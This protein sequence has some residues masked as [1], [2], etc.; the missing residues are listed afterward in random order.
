MNTC[1]RCGE[2]NLTDHVLCL[3]CR[4]EAHLLYVKV[5]CVACHR[6][7]L[8]PNSEPIPLQSVCWRFDC[9]AR[10]EKAA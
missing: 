9:S 6:A 3:T 10:K 1:P 4:N 8:I 5:V 2:D 7:Y